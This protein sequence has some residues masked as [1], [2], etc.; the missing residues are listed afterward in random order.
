MLVVDEGTESTLEE[1]CSE[2]EEV[3]VGCSLFSVKRS[4]IGWLEQRQMLLHM[5]N[6][7]G[8]KDGRGYPTSIVYQSLRCK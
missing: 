5:E 2:E 3:G 7:K 1:G 4:P 8:T 6:R